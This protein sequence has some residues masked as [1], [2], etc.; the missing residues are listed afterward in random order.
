M[1]PEPGRLSTTI[2]CPSARD[3]RPVTKRQTMA[4][5]EPAA[6]DTITRM[7]FV[8]QLCAAAGQVAA[9]SATSI[10]ARSF[11]ISSLLELYDLLR[12]PVELL[13]HARLADQE[14]VAAPA[15]GALGD[16]GRVAHHVH[17]LP[18][19]HRL[20]VPDKRTLDHIVALAVRVQA[21]LLGTLVPL[22]ES[23]VL[24]EDLAAFRA[25]LHP[26]QRELLRFEHESELVLHLLRGAPEH[27]GA[28]ELGVEAPRPVVLDQ[29]REL[30]AFA[31]HAVLLVAVGEDRGGADRTRAGEKQSLLAAVL[32]ADVLGDCRDLELP[33]A[34]LHR[35]ESFLHRLVLHRRGA[36]D[37]LEL[38]GAF[39][40]LDAV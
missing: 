36:A 17:V 2:D 27:A 11:T 35:G 3:S 6:K 30:V 15:V 8:G 9:A 12:K 29:D 19:H 33:H 7:G 13:R 4:G 25:R 32:V 1:F 5:A 24:G 21:L 23:V 40:R 20:V 22:H 37:A 10:S 18:Y 14:I 34:G 39:D 38:L 26:V 16:V 31:Q 28:S